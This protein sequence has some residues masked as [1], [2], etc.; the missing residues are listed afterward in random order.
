MRACADIYVVCYLYRRRHSKRIAI[1]K[2]QSMGG[3]FPRTQRSAANLV[4]TV[5]VVACLVLQALQSFVL[6]PLAGAM[7]LPSHSAWIVVV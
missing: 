7:F 5:G 4:A 1:Q 3:M 6:A 2:Y